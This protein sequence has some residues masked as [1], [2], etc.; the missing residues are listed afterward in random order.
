[1]IVGSTEEDAGFDR[2]TSDET[3]AGLIDFAVS[4]VPELAGVPLEKSWAG[5][6]P[7]SRDGLPYLGQAPDLENAFVAA[8]HYRSGLQLSAG[9]ALV[10]NDLFAGKTPAIDLSIFRPDRHAGVETSAAS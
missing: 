8:G 9:T 1:V 6:R 2:S 10:M 3:I 4:L 5:L 7:A